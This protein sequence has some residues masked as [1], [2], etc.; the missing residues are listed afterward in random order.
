MKFTRKKRFKRYGRVEHVCMGCGRV[1]QTH[2][3][4]TDKKTGR[5]EYTCPGV[6]LSDLMAVQP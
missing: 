3:R 6:R 5:G 1:G 4:V 2:Y